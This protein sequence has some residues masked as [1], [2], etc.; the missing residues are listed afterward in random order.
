[1]LRAYIADVSGISSTE[2]RSTFSEYR[3]SRI[4]SIKPA[5]KIRQS[6]GAELL[7][8]HAVKDLFPAL[9][10]P[11]EIGIDEHRKPFF[12]KLPFCF[13][14]SHSGEFV[15]CAISDKA[16]GI[17]I[18][19]GLEYKPQLARRFFSAAE[20]EKIEKA[21]SRDKEFARIWTAKESI[22]KFSGTGLTKTISEV[23]TESCSKYRIY[24]L[25]TDE[26]CVALCTQEYIDSFELINYKF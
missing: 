6:I 2:D 21:V 4:K 19:A 7:L 1:M 22:L 9:K 13:S 12:T 14:I 3:L 11:L 17:D 10:L 24:H 20:Q 26:A 23:K 18:E 5:Q 15:V 16:V 25:Q 8:I